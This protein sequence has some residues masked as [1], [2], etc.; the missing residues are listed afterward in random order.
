MKSAKVRVA[1]SIVVVLANFLSVFAVSDPLPSLYVTPLPLSTAVM[2]T[3]SSREQRPALSALMSSPDWMKL[4]GIPAHV[5]SLGLMTKH[6]TTVITVGI[7][8]YLTLDISL[9]AAL[10]SKTSTIKCEEVSVFET[11]QWYRHEHRLCWR[12]KVFTG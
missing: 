6:S 7:Y 8:S 11:N 10:S 12:S 4:A 5:L 1:E 9:I 2:G 3:K